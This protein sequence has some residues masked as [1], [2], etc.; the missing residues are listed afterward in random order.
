QSSERLSAYRLY[1]TQLFSFAGKSRPFPI[2]QK[3]L[4][5]FRHNLDKLPAIVVLAQ[6]EYFGHFQGL[7]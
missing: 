4:C 1:A 3:E 5:L 2:A 7:A 6:Q